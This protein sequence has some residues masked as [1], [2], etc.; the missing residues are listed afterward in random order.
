[1]RLAV[2]FEQHHGQRPDYF[3]DGERTKLTHHH[4]PGTEIASAY[5]QTRSCWRGHLIKAGDTHTHTHTHQCLPKIYKIY[6]DRSDK[7]HEAF[8][9]VTLEVKGLVLGKAHG[10]VH[11]AQFEAAGKRDCVTIW[12]TKF[13]CVRT[14]A[15]SAGESGK[16]IS[17]QDHCVDSIIYL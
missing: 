5:T 14:L 7:C 8:T 4:K 6:E 15:L 16:C 1:M 2:E 12:L 9:D 11:Q 3:S 13:R 10:R 17:K